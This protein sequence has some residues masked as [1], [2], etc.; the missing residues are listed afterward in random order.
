MKTRPWLTAVMT[1]AAMFFMHDLKAQT[2]TSDEPAASGAASAS[3]EG[4]GPYYIRDYLYVPLRSGNSSSHRIVHKGLKSGTAVT[5]LEKDE[6]TGFSHVRT[7]KG[8]DGWLRSQYLQ[9]QPTAAMRLKSAEK[10]IEQL[11]SKTG[12]MSEKLISSERTNQQ[13]ANTIKQLERKNNSLNKELSR[14]KGLSKNVIDLDEQNKTLIK[15]N[16]LMRSKQATLNAENQR[17]QDQLK[18]EEFINGVIAVILGMLATLAIQY[19]TRS[20]RRSEWG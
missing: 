3:A 11:S 9:E 4:S 2:V 17:L 14:I 13:Q 6:S 16:E 12:P 20:R 15:D 7:R 8:T 18:R 19:L 1:A 5:V 10:T